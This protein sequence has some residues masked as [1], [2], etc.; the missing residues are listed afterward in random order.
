MDN[1]TTIEQLRQNVSE[2][3]ERRNWRQFHDAKELSIGIS[4][5]AGELLQ[6]FRFKNKEQVETKA[7]TQQVRE[8]LVDILYFIL[9]FSELYN[10]D[11]TTQLKNKLKKNNEKYPIETSLNNNL[12]YNEK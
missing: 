10:I 6:H 1:Q 2:F 5:E 11:L 4:T 3:C 12:K 7:Q 9:R 8:E